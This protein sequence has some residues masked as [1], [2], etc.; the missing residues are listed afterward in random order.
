MYSELK[1]VTEELT[2]QLPDSLFAWENYM[3]SRRGLGEYEEAN[4]A[5]DRLLEM[6][7]R[8]VRFWTM[9]ADT[10]YRLE[11]YREAVNAAERAV[12]IDQDYPPARRIREKAVRMMY[13][14]KEKRG[15]IQRRP[16]G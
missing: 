13:Q 12:R 1:K 9:K 14:R 4:A 10:L 5:L 11:R 7:A 6:D 8:N 2:R 16:Q 3:R 15:S